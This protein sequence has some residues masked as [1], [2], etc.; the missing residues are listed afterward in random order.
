MAISKQTKIKTKRSEGRNENVMNKGKFT[1]FILGKDHPCVMAQSV[2]TLDNLDFHT[3]ENFGSR[4]AAKKMLSGLKAYLSEYDFESHDFFSFI[5]VFS[6]IKQY[7]EREFETVLWQQ[8]QFLHEVDDSVWDPKVSSDP[9]NDN[10]SFSILGKAFYIVG[11]HPNSSRKARQ[12]PRATIVFNLH[13]QFE[14][15]RKMG[16]YHTVRD[17]IRQRDE[18]L[19]GNMNPMLE[20]FGDNSEANQ[21]SGRKVGEDWKCPFHH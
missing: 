16:V 18:Q 7:N 4:K 10:F 20:D 11:M 2:F 17:K 6:D 19:Q 12:S 14:K 8:L 3:Y 1:D 15:L 13:G 21:Y 9:E 5:A